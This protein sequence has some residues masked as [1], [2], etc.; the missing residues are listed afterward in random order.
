VRALVLGLLLAAVSQAQQ[1][2]FERV[3]TEAA[4]LRQPPVESEDRDSIVARD[5]SALHAAIRD[6]VESL[7]PTFRP[8]LD[9]EF[10]PLGPRLN[11]E[12]QRA[13][14]LE[15][16]DPLS[17]FHPGYVSRLEIARSQQDPDKVSVTVGVSQPCGSED[18][19][20]VYDY[21]QGPP[22][23]VLE[24]H[25][26]RDQ[27]EEIE[28]VRLSQRDTKGRQLILV[29]RHSL[30]CASTWYRLS[31]DLFRWSG[32]GKPILSGEHGIWFDAS[33]PWQARLDP[34]ELLMEVRDRSI[35][36]GIGNRSHVLH[37]NVAGAAVERV[38]PV[39]L[40]PQDFVDEWLTRPWSEMQTR[41]ADSDRGKLRRWHES[42]GIR[43]AE[44]SLVQEC[45]QHGQ[46]QIGI[47]V[48]W[49]GDKSYRSLSV[50][51]FLCSS[52]RNTDSR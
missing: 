37:F 14:L 4:R 3:V 11:A 26:T 31:Y 32:E 30:Q 38:D 17:E 33:N 35:D 27:D 29:L 15:S 34:D 44:F 51:T 9:A 5:R 23:R 8:A 10:S 25:P 45:L 1:Q 50:S 16:G 39:A 13:G 41:S 28:G 40:Q 46:W 24:S 47:D 21:S 52:P 49:L 36:D 48:S 7:L 6:W 18:F 22:R 12:L 43:F 19:A 20:Y 2:A 42:L